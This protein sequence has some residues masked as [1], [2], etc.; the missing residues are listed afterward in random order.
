MARVNEPNPVEQG[1]AAFVTVTA[2][3]LA[4]TAG[5][6][7]ILQGISAVAGDGVFRV[8]PHYAFDLDVTGWGWIHIGLGVLL[9][10]VALALIAGATWARIVAAVFAAL[11]ILA[12]FLWLPYYPWWSAIVIVADIVVIWAVTAWQPNRM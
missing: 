6:L 8:V 4:L 11:S 12:N 10:L 7:S 5:I 3:V 2:G 9:V 1:I